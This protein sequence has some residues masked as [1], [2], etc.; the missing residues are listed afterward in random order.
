MYF[1]H[2]EE[3]EKPQEEP[4]AIRG[5]RKGLVLKGQEGEV[6]CSHA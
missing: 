6:R 1:A 2:R 3:I 5:E 4:G